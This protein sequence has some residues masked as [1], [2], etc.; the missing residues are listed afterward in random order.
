VYPGRAVKRERG[1]CAV[2]SDGYGEI[3][4]FSYITGQADFSVSREDFA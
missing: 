1:Y 2:V 4:I 3:L